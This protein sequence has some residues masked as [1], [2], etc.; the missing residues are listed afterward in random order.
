MSSI[1]NNF[2]LQ[3]SILKVFYQRIEYPAL[4]VCV[5][6]GGYPSRHEVVLILVRQSHFDVRGAQPQVITKR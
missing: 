3:S 5:S 4:S 1:F 2:L 6:V